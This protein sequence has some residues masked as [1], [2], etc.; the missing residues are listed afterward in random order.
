MIE[1]TD[2]ICHCVV[3]AM[4]EGMDNV[5]WNVAVSTNGL[6]TVYPL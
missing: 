1:E 4:I 3:C 2:V 6:P 5:L